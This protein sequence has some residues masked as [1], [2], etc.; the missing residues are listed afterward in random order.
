MYRVDGLVRRAIPLQQAASHEFLGIRINSKMIEQLQLTENSLATL[1]QA[2]EKVSLPVILDERI[3][4]GCALIAGGF[5]ET[6]ILA[7]LFGA[8]TIHA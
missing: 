3:P 6:E 2:G 7:E 1:E 4:E 5:A 8:I